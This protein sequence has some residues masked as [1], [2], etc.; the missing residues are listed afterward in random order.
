M[1]P[2]S[3]LPPGQTA[4]MANL[5]Q[6]W[7]ER[8]QDSGQHLSC[9]MDPD[10]EDFFQWKGK[11][12]LEFRK[13]QE[14]MPVFELARSLGLNMDISEFKMPE[15]S[16]ARKQPLSN[17]R[18]K[19]INKQRELDEE[20]KKLK[21]MQ[22]K[23]EQKFGLIA[24]RWKKVEAGQ[25]LLKQNLV[26]YNNFVKEKRGKVADEISRRMFEKQRQQEKKKTSLRSP[27]NIQLKSKNMQLTI[28]TP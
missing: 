9:K 15:D 3:K 22:K 5:E 19:E 10:Q 17:Q 18:I 28:F 8:G 27:I 12:E 25:K 26:K 1:S 13:Q 4:P 21:D 11:L 24:E 2:A 6:W 20:Q 14:K 7:L 23:L 16:E